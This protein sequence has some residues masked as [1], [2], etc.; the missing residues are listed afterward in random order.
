MRAAQPGVPP[1]APPL[2]SLS[3]A[4]AAALA[5]P[6]LTLPPPPTSRS[7]PPP[8][9]PPTTA[10]H[11]PHGFYE[12]QLLGFFSQFGRVSRVRVARSKR[13][14]RCKGYAYVEFAHGGVAEVAAGA[15]HG[16]LMLKQALSV[17][18]LPRGEVHPE[19]FKGAERPFRAIPW[20]KIEA[21]RHN[22]PR[23][24]EAHA[25]RVGRAA[26]RDVAR[27]KKLAA[28]GIDY[29]YED[30]LGKAAKEA[31]A[32]G[33]AGS[34]KGKA[35]SSVAGGSGG[36]NKGRAKKADAVPA[37][38]AAAPAVPARKRRAAA[39]AIAEDVPTPAPALKKRAA[40]SRK[41]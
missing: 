26:A 14:A 4:A 19:L 21:A 16:H 29:D 34:S 9:P 11:L 10:S 17:R 38:A 18:N 7:T 5:P 28:L 13:T 22:A 23:T 25:K 39:A 40:V 30:V 3:A 27:R 20:A 6:A 33:A 41:K 37:I 35:P 24:A 2:P 15:M 1:L 31:A 12:K 8:P 36:G 32:E